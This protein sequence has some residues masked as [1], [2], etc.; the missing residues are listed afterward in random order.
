MAERLVPGR[1]FVDDD[2]DAREGGDHGTRVANL[3]AA[4]ANGVGTTGACP[5]CMIMP[6]RV[7]GERAGDGNVVGA[8]ADAAAGIVWAADHG[9]QVINMSFATVTNS[10]MLREAVQHAAGKGAVLVG[11]AGDTYGS[12]RHYP[13][14]FDEV[15]AVSS[16][17]DPKNNSLSDR[18][19]DLQTPSVFLVMDGAGRMSGLGGTSAAAAIVSGVAGLVLSVRP[20]SSDHEVRDA[21]TRAARTPLKQVSYA[22]PL[23]DAAGAVTGADRTDRVAPVITALNGVTEGQLLDGRT[24]WLTA[25]AT[26]DRAVARYE[27]LIDGRAPTCGRSPCLRWSAIS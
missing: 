1:D 15:I 6:V 10:S 7:L 14:A 19:I 27:F 11:S 18:W 25:S 23:L 3:I 5:N 22:P 16:T 9:A 2:E 20:G 24:K 21:I 12:Q 4:A 26:D 8:T 13:A 17:G